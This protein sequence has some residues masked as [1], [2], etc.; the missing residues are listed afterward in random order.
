MTEAGP[1]F[2]FAGE[3]VCL[4]FSVILMLYFADRV[5]C[6]LFQTLYELARRHRLLG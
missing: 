3:F 5:R 1:A 6:E 2:L 4:L